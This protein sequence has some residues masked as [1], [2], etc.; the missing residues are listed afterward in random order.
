RL[1]VLDPAEGGYA[2]AAAALD[3]PVGSLGPTRARCLAT[4]RGHLDATVEG[5]AVNR[6][7]ARGVGR[8]ATRSPTSSS[9]PSWRR[10]CAELTRSR[11]RWSTRPAAASAGGGWTPS[12]PG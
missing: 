4:L 11:P 7:M 9:P 1:L 6:G 3:M 5:A 12:S 8:W 10:C 2:A